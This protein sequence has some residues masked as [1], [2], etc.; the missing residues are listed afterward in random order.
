M[1]Y[2]GAGIQP[3]GPLLP[4][5]LHACLGVVAAE[6]VTLGLANQGPVLGKLCL[7]VD[8]LTFGLIVTSLLSNLSIFICNNC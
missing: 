3:G 5:A 4:T 2:P 1:G 7:S 8:A 6:T